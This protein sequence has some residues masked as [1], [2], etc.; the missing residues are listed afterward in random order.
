MTRVGI[1]YDIHPFVSGRPLVL[2]GIN[3][4]F[5]KGL[6]G[7]SDADVL[8]HAIIDAI[9]GAMGHGDIGRVFGVGTP[10]VMGISSIVLLERTYQRLSSNGYK[11]VNIDST[12]IAQVPKLTPHIL[13]MRDKLAGVLQVTPDAINIK[14]TTHKYLGYLGSGE[15][16][17]VHAV[18]QISQLND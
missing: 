12:V 4:P 17:A 8:T 18:V 9:L 10:D 1:G 2:G 14:S 6:E 13:K 7:D 16:I 15:A 3:I 11:I 5:D